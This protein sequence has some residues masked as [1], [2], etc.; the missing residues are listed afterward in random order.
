MCRVT[1]HENHNQHLLAFRPRPDCRCD[2]CGGRVKFAYTCEDCDFDL[3]VFC[4]FDERELRDGHEEQRPTLEHFSHPKHLLIL[5]EYALLEE[6]DNCHVCDKPVIGTPTY[7]CTTDAFDC[8]NFYLHKSCAELPT[9]INHHTHN[10]HSL[11]LLP[12]PDKKVCNV[13]GCD[14]KFAY[15]C[16]DC[17][18]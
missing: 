6:D 3:C 13:C 12:R 5:N 4:V 15:A 17:N 8:E 2:I 14:V 1:H 18:F 9:L 7:T 11:A 10:K 16:K